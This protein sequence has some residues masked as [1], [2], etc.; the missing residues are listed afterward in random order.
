MLE[1]G[2]QPG[3]PEPPG[4]GTCPGAGPT[5]RGHRISRGIRR[6]K[7]SLWLYKRKRVFLFPP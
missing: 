4:A 2:G 1:S 3:S 7:H 5:P 6:V